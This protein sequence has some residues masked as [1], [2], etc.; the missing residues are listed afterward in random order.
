MFVK[1]N[2]PKMR[3]PRSALQVRWSISDHD[4]ITVLDQGVD[5]AIRSIDKSLANPITHIVCRSRN[6]MLEL[7]GRHK[8]EKI[9]SLDGFPRLSANLTAEEVIEAI[10]LGIGRIIATI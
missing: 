3:P 6:L 8:W 5:I 2:R 4:A 1:S 9:P 7:F 10:R